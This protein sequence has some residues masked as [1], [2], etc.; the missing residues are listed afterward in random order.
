[1]QGCAAPLNNVLGT[2]ICKRLENVFNEVVFLSILLVFP[3]VLFPFHFQSPPD[4]T[5]MFYF[6]F[7]RQDLQSLKSMYL[8]YTK[9]SVNIKILSPSSEL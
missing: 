4:A 9:A 2:A 8:T 3:H 6:P 1:M 5:F 7:K